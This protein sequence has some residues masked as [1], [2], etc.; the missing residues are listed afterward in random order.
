VNFQNGIIRRHRLKCNIS[1]PAVA[2][3]FTWFSQLVHCRWGA[4]LLLHAAD[5]ADLVTQLAAGF[6]DGMDVKP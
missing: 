1:V 3:E 5:D 6:R 4:F 2:S